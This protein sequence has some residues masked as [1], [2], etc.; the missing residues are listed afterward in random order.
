[1]TV[2]NLGIVNHAHVY[3]D[4]KV[5][6]HMHCH[7]YTD[8]VGKK[9]ANNVASLIMKTLRDL[10]L[11]RS[12]EQGGELNIVFDNCTGQ[13]KNNT[14]LR[15]VAWLAQMGHFNEI[16]F[17]FLI[18]GHTKN[19]AD[20]L[21]NS[22]KTLYR[23]KNL[24][25]FDQLVEA[26]GTSRT[27]TI[28]PAMSEDFLDYGKLFDFIYKKLQGQVKQNH[29]FTCYWGNPDEICVK[30]SV[31]DDY[32][33]LRILQRQFFDLTYPQALEIAAD[34]LKTLEFEGINPYKVYELFKHYRPY[35]P[36][37]FHSDDMYA[38]PSSEVL[39][40]VMAEKVDR[41]VFRAALKKK[42][43]DRAKEQLENV[44]FGN[45]DEAVE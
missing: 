1:M 45:D 11:L 17:I 34:Q 9:G 36:V 10:N 30:E 3:P 41:R 31:L 43:Y 28:H 24:Y 4:G 38:E 5:S 16:N 44:A 20:R 39:A 25:T 37:E 26:L 33:I 42:K 27:I 6:K 23:K 12:D 2:N 19:A 29:I 40:K 14:V 7:I 32:S 22:L 35:V 8:A 18:V 13:N 21:F 15:L